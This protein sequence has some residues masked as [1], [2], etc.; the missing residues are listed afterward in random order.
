MEIRDPTLSL[1][2][3]C[4]N[5]KNPLNSAGAVMESIQYIVAG[6]CGDGQGDGS[7]GRPGGRR[8]GTRTAEHRDPCWRKPRRRGMP[9]ADRT[10]RAVKRRD[11]RRWLCDVSIPWRQVFRDSCHW[12]CALSTNAAGAG[13]ASERQTGRSIRSRAL[14]GDQTARKAQREDDEAAAHQ[15]VEPPGCAIIL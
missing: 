3:Q 14:L 10:G 8:R 12:R 11:R 2:G 15:P 7:S 9:R 4:D 6:R 1:T 5:D 13:E